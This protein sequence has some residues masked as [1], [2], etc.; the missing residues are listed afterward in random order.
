MLI[1]QVTDA[2]YQHFG[3][4]DLNDQASRLYIP[5]NPPSYEHLIRSQVLYPI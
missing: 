3:F 1:R 5:M 2:F 4:L